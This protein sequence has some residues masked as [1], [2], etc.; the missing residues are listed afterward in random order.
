[1]RVRGRFLTNSDQG[2]FP[3]IAAGAR[4]IL[5]VEDEVLIRIALSEFLQDCG[6]VVY[7]VGS[8]EKAMEVL[9]SHAFG[10]DIVFT[11]IELGGSMD[12]LGLA[13]WI[14]ANHPRTLVLITT[15]DRQRAEAATELCEKNDVIWKPHDYELILAT[16]KSK[17]GDDRAPALPHA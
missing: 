8:A 9:A 14:R 3:N 7:G 6:Y 1:M 5:L 13:K 15:G 2:D 12:G 4:S 10:I 11:D 17:L 16:M